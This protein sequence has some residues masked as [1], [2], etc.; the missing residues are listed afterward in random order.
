MKRISSHVV[1]VDRGTTLLF[2]DFQHSGDMWTGSGP[3]SRSV[4][5]AFE[6]PFASP[7]QVLVTLDM[8]DM[9]NASNQ[10]ADISAEEVTRTGFRLVFRTWSDTRVARA[11]ASWIAIGELP[12]YEE[13]QLY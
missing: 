7:P 4:D 1:G 3:R 10:R 8:W 11:R 5:M 12:D 9:D 2:S 6:T 13:W